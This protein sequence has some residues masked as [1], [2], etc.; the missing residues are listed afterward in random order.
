L[1]KK[2]PEKHRE[3]FAAHSYSNQASLPSSSIF[4]VWRMIFPPATGGAGEG[5]AFIA[6][7]YAKF[8]SSC[9]PR[10][11]EDM[12]GSTRDLA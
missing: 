6:S 3:L 11:S 7:E 8:L 4:M 10:P 2:L 12:P 5:G 1:P 9:Y